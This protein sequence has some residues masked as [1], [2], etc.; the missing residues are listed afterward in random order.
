MPVQQIYETSS[1]EM[2]QICICLC[3]GW[4]ILLTANTQCQWKRRVT[5]NT[6]VQLKHLCISNLLIKLSQY[7]CL[8]CFVNLFY[9][10][11][12]LSPCFLPASYVSPF[13]DLQIIQRWCFHINTA[14]N[15]CMD[16][17]LLCEIP[18]FCEFWLFFFSVIWVILYHKICECS[19]FLS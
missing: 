3:N 19:K 4:N 2:Q 13:A 12:F 15:T 5:T 18:Y 7:S 1:N 10:I 17:P 16:C 11:I 6:N 8:S 9:I 14:V